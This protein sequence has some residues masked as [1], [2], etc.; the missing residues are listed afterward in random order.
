[1]AWRE[2]GDAM[3]SFEPGAGPRELSGP[4][5]DPGDGADPDA[6]ATRPCHVRNG[7]AMADVND[8]WLGGGQVFEAT[9]HG[10]LWID[11]NGEIHFHAGAPTEGHE[12]PSL[13][14]ARHRSW[15]IVLRRGQTT[16]VLLSHH[17]DHEEDIDHAPLRLKSGAVRDRV[18]D[19]VQHGPDFTS[20]RRC[21]AQGT[22]FEIKLSRS[23]HRHV[24]ATVRHGRICSVS[25]PWIT[26]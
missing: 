2:V 26:R 3:N 11:E 25:D 14:E 8:E 16:W 9:W 12:E 1:M 10:A 17:W 15:R 21:T 4:H 23:G 18:V 24:R 13:H 19:L 22:G 5:R 7:L 6:A 20:I